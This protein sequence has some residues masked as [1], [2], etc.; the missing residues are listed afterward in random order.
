VAIHG[1]SLQPEASGA[2][3][4]GF[5]NLKGVTTMK[6]Y[7]HFATVLTGLLGARTAIRLTVPGFMPCPSKTSDNPVTATG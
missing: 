1:N 7:Q 5:H 6:T 2:S 4:G 3:A